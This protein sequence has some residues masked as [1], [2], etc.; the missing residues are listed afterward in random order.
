MPKISPEK[1]KE[2]NSKYREKKKKEM[3]FV[4]EIEDDSPQIEIKKIPISNTLNISSCD[5][6]LEDAEECEEDYNADVTMDK[7]TYKF[8]LECYEKQKNNDNKTEIKEEV[9]ESE[10]SEIPAVKKDDGFFFLVKNQAKIA[11]ATAVPII[12]LQLIVSGAK[13]CRRQCLPIPSTSQNATCGDS[14][15]EFQSRVVNLD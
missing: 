12:A 14:T 5:D 3:S 15:Q 11:L 1:R 10:K 13:L 9:K 6:E 7:E 8:L 4:E 2:Y